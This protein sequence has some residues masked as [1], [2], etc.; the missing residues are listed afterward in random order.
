M[1]KQIENVDQHAVLCLA[2]FPRKLSLNIR[3]ILPVP[4]IY[5]LIK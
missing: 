2:L 5:K 1:R 3:R 4:T